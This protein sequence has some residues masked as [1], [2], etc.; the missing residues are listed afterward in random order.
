MRL[1]S[2]SGCPGASDGKEPA[3]PCGRPRLDP[4]VRKTPGRG[5]GSPLQDSCLENPMD[6]GAWRAIVG[7]VAESDTTEPLTFQLSLMLAAPRGGG[8]RLRR[9]SIR[10]L[11]RCWGLKRV[12]YFSLSTLGACPVPVL[13]KPDLWAVVP[14]GV[15]VTLL[16]GLLQIHQFQD[17][18]KKTP[19]KSSLPFHPAW[20]VLYKKSRAFAKC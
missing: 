7:G 13:G 2:P 19:T 16:Q 10:Q 20:T 9:V 6:S 11:R 18:A 3:C 15:Q 12:F 14:S 17:E 5:N 8:V 4:W 1:S